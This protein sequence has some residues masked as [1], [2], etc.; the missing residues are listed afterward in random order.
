MSKLNRWK[1]AAADWA[2]LSC[3]GLSF[4]KSVCIM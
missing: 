1:A 4:P 3:E 2:A